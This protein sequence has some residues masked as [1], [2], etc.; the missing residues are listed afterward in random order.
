MVSAMDARL[1]NEPRPVAVRMVKHLRQARPGKARHSLRE[2]LSHLRRVLGPGAIAHR[3]EA[4]ALAADVP[5]VVDARVFYAACDAA[6]EP[7][8]SRAR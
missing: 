7:S 5:L 6:D 4:V 3:S 2:T 8:R 1:S